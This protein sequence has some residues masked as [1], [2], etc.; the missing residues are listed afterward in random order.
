MHSHGNRYR[1]RR[2]AQ[3]GCA[4]PFVRRT[5]AKRRMEAGRRA[6]L[7]RLGHQ[8]ALRAGPGV[9][10]RAGRELLAHRRDEPAD[11]RRRLGVHADLPDLSTIEPIGRRSYFGGS[12]E[13]NAAFTVFFDTPNT[14]A[15]ALIGKPSA[16][17]SRRIS[18]QSSTD[19]IPSGPPGSTTAR[20][21]DQGVKIRLPRR[22]QFSRAVDKVVAGSNPVSPTRESAPS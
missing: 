14:R 9:L 17:C 18:A 5:T 7:R 16:R 11:P 22:G 8:P 12:S 4:V 3:A 20:P 2:P 15:T 13:A 1:A 21:P 6:A 19:N 10:L